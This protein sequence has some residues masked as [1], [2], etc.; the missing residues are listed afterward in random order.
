MSHRNPILLVVALLLA[1]VPASR[2]ELLKVSPFLMPQSAASSAPAANTPVQYMGWVDTT[3]G[4]LFRI[5][6]T[7]RRAGVFLKLGEK[8][9]SL[10]VEVKQHDDDR[11]TLTVEHGGQTITLQEHEA[12]IL[13]SGAM[14][15]MMP[16]PVAQMPMPNVPP[17]VTQSVV[18]N[19]TPADEQR[20]LEAVAAEVARRRALREQATEQL[21]MAQPTYQSGTPRPPMPMAATRQDLMQAQRR[22]P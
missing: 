8:D 9:P 7:T 15:Q 6:D 13:S 3:E 16:Q 22:A 4:R 5:Y 10:D 1:A 14:P 21:R 12:K 20:R 18:L 2:A 19:P 11:D 17:A